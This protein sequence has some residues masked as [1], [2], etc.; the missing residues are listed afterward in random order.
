METSLPAIT[1]LLGDQPF[2]QGIAPD[3]LAAIAECA[4]PV[5]F[6][7]DE[8]LFHEGQPANHFYLITHGQVALEVHVPGRGNQILQTVSPHEVVGWSWLFP[9]Y[10]WHLDGRAQTLLRVID[11]NGLCLRGKCDS[12]HDLGYALMERFAQTIVAR[13]QATRLQLIEAYDAPHR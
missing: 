12:D 1:Q 8:Y 2:L 10:R 7:A 13:R 4:H 11:F 6:R 5:T 3:K 9:P